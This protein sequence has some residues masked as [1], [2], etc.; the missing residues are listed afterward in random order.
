MTTRHSSTDADVVVIGG[1]AAGLAAALQ[2][3]RQ[4]RRV[5]VLDGGKPLN[6]PAAHVHGYLGLDG[7]PPLDLVARGRDEVRS[8]G[9]AVVEDVDAVARR[10]DDG[11]LLVDVSDGSSLR[12]RRLLLATG[13]T[14]E[15]PPIPGVA[16]QW[17]RGVVHCPYCHGW[18][19]RDQR[20]VVVATATGGWHQAMLFRQQTEHLTVVVHE[21]EVPG[22]QA[23]GLAARGVAIVEGPV[24]R[25]TQDADGRLTGVELADGGS[26]PADAVVVAATM[27][28]RIDAVSALGVVAVA[29]PMGRGDLVPTDPQGRTTVDDVYAAGSIVEP[30]QVAQAASSGA[31][32]GAFINMDLVLDDTARALAAPGGP[33]GHTPVDRDRE[34]DQP[35]SG[36]PDEVA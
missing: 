29:D 2:L 4:R 24:D 16:E 27:R 5:V 36:R 23:E 10:D 21:G 3:G 18:E 34:R 30:L 12:T 26:R 35:S 15:L 33:D 22:D 9:V 11:T 20:V 8:Y 32:T 19:V 25:L 28:P 17:G 7:L 31:L 14:A 13:L 1:G 6:A